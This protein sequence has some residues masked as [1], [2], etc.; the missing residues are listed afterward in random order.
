MVPV[1]KLEDYNEKQLDEIPKHLTF[2]N[3]TCPTHSLTRA[4]FN[5]FSV[6]LLFGVFWCFLMQELDLYWQEHVRTTYTFLL[7]DHAV[8]IKSLMRSTNTFVVKSQS[9]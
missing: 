6:A 7:I 9:V 4:L 5:F 1:I 3:L 2:R 8:P